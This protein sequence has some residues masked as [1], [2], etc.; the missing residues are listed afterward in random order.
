MPTQQE[1]TQS[2][3]QAAS[4]HV[5]LYAQHFDIKL[6]YSEASLKQVDD[7]ISKFHPEGV[8]SDGTFVPYMAYV[9]EVARRNIGGE[10]E[11]TEDRGPSVKL[12][13]GEK[14]A[15][16]FPYA[17]VAKRFQE[18]PDESIAFK[19]AATKSVLD[20]GSGL[21]GDPKLREGESAAEIEPP[22]SGGVIDISKGPAIVFLMVAAADGVIDK[23]EVG[24]LRKIVQ[25]MH[26]HESKLFR[27]ALTMLVADLE[28]TLQSCSVPLLEN[29]AALGEVVG[30]VRE[31]FPDQADLDC[32]ALYDLGESVAKASGGFLGFGAKIGKEEETTLRLLKGFLGVSR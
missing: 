2:L 8:M 22:P 12:G 9:G 1:L 11:E 25:E 24:A 21:S 27:A 17:W 10:W 16:V 3:E 30:S 18:G 19:Y 31:T 28:A 5:S 29:L 7:A 15:Q 23:K 32:S 4:M 6:D 20:L 14:S 13:A 26:T